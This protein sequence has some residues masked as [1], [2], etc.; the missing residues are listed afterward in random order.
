[1]EEMKFETDYMNEMMNRNYEVDYD[2]ADLDAELGE[3]DDEL[4][5]EMMKN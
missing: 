1:M 2:E 3:L 5:E 4:F